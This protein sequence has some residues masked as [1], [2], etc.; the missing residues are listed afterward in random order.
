MRDKEYSCGDNKSLAHNYAS[1]V[2]IGGKDK[3]GKNKG[4]ID[5]SDWETD[6]LFNPEIWIPHQLSKDSEVKVWI[7]NVEG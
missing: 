7:Y 4:I 6:M 5:Y 3:W 1:Y 2:G